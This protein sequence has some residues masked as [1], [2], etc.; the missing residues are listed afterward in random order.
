MHS[1]RRTNAK[2]EQRDKRKKT[3]SL[4]NF[5]CEFLCDCQQQPLQHTREG[6]F[7]LPLPTSCP[8]MMMK[9]HRF[10]SSFH[11]QLISY[12]CLCVLSPFAKVPF[13]L[14]QTVSWCREW[15]WKSGINKKQFSTRWALE[16]AFCKTVHWLKRG[17]RTRAKRTGQ[18]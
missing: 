9:F 16:M 1:S 6:S 4:L 5:E 12:L 7:F 15:N 2:K 3:Q 11:S 18:L 14:V 10:S 17:D 13:E 8:K